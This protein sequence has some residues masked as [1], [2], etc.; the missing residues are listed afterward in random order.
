MVAVISPLFYRR[1]SDLPQ[2]YLYIFV[3]FGFLSLQR[4]RPHSSNTKSLANEDD[5]LPIPKPRAL[6]LTT[7]SLSRFIKT[8]L[9][10]WDQLSDRSP[11]LQCRNIFSVLSEFV[12]PL[13]QRIFYRAADNRAIFHKDVCEFAA[14]YNIRGRSLRSHLAWDWRKRLFFR[15]FFLWITLCFAQRCWVSYQII[16]FFTPFIALEHGTIVTW[17]NN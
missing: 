6:Y 13:Q 4:H 17:N 3:V 14:F 9:A 5:T 1:L 10:C 12:V 8:S 16:L 7:S 11:A 15:Y 2:L